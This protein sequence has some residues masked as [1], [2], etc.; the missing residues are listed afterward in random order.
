M[1]VAVAAEAAAAIPMA[2]A[3]AIPIALYSGV[4][5][6]NGSCSGG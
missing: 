3:A 6:S 1:A 5:F 4:C 2:T